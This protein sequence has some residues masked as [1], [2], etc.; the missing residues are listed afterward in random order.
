M[1]EP[2]NREIAAAST[3]AKPPLPPIPRLVRSGQRMTSG[4]EW[5]GES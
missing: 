2:E 5:S 3:D 1:S 4:Q